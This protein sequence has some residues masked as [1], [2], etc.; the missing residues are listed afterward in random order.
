M[1]TTAGRVVIKDNVIV[2]G[3]F[4]PIQINKYTMISANTVIRP[5]Y[6]IINK[7]FQY[8]PMTIGQHTFI[9][10]NCIIEA[11]SIG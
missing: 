9:G 1:S 11:S 8:I 4:A 2:R 10:K 3:D 5:S 7:K 6:D